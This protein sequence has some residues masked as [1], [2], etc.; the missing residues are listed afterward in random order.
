MLNL[1]DVSSSKPHISAI[2]SFVS[3]NFNS[4]VK[5]SLKKIT[6]ITFVCLFIFPTLTFADELILVKG[7]GVEVCE[8]Y[9]KELQGMSLQDMVCG[10]GTDFITVLDVKIR[11][12]LCCEEEISN[13]TQDFKRPKW[14]RLDLRENKELVK[15]IHKFYGVGDQFGKL[16]ALDE[17]NGFEKLMDEMYTRMDALYKTS[18]DIDNDGS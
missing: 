7:K 12:P 2:R 9:H 8:A 16:R 3:P 4:Q 10:K 6:A 5:N 17:D 14:E 1:W 15:K 13:S 18:V 11:I